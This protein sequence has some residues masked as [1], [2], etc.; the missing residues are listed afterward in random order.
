MEFIENI[1]SFGLTKQEAT[2][3]KTLLEEGELTG[4]EIAKIN[5]TSRSNTYASLSM[6]VDKGAIY[7]VEGTSTKYI[8]IDPEE[9]CNNKISNLQKLRDNIIKVKPIRK[10]TIEGYITI[11]GKNH[12][13]DKMKNMIAKTKIRLYLSAD[14]ETLEYLREELNLLKNKNIKIVLICD[15][16]FEFQGALIFRSPKSSKQIRLIVDSSIV[17]TGDIDNGDDSTCL[18]SKKKNLIDLIKDSLKNE[19][20]LLESGI[21]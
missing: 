1:I 19:I 7:L 2:I 4:Y 8:A 9:F 17:L 11:K 12:I 20:K 5:G 18:Y 14:N 3:Y 16:F 21:I 6:L 10:E 13:L 15:N